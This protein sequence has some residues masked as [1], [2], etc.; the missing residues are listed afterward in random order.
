VGARAGLD[1]LRYRAGE[2]YRLDA[3]NRVARFIELN[4]YHRLQPV[5]FGTP[6]RAR[7]EL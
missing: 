7:G 6:L 3:A 1:I 4:R 2:T 5:L